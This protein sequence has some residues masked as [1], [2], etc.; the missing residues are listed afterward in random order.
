[1]KTSEIDHG[2]QKLRREI[3][4]MRRA[5]TPHV[6][7]GFPAEVSAA[8]QDGTTVTDVALFNEFG[9]ERIPE[10]PFLRTAAD[11]TV[12]KRTR[13]TGELLT[14]IT[15]GKMT[16]SQALSRMGVYMV[17]VIQ[18]SITD[19]RTPPNAPSTIARKKSSNPLIDTG[20]MRQSVTFK[21]HM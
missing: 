6:A 16:L 5:G 10:R 4:K 13:M 18:K 14:M 20:Q 12:E 21:K 7:V 2:Y 3:D 17:S 15:T 8:Y 19:L 11:A 1:M 9:T